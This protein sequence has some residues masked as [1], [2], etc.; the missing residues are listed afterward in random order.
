MEQVG[1]KY[2]VVRCCY[3]DI[4][5]IVLQTNDEKEALTCMAIHNVFFGKRLTNE[6]KVQERVCVKK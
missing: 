1:Y 3:A 6:Y 4:K 5:Q 2:R